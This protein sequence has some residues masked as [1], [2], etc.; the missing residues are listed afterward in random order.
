M[1]YDEG[2]AAGMRRAA[3]LCA[4]MANDHADMAL[5]GLSENARNR[6]AMEAALTKARYAILAA[7]P[8]PAPWTPPP[9]AERPEGFECLGRGVK[10]S[11]WHHIQWNNGRW[12]LRSPGIQAFGLVAF[13]PLPPT[14]EA[15]P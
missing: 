4:A 11:S 13:A 2:F 10:G 5:I 14:P 8:A 7:I 9:E 1:T 3:E 6:E 12:W 15:Q